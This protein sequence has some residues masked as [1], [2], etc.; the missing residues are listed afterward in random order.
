[1]KPLSQ[2][3]IKFLRVIVLEKFMPSGAR[4]QVRHQRGAPHRHQLR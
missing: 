1:M 2:G 3:K 4:G